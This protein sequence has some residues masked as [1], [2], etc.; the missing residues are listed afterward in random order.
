MTDLDAYERKILRELQSDASL[1]TAELAERIG[2]SPS[3]CWRRVDRL[4]REGVIRKRVALIDRRKVGLNAHVFAQVK[5]N[6]HGRANLDEFSAAIRG[7]PEVL[8]AY[9]LMGTMDFML[10]IVAE[11]IDAYERFFFDKLSKLPGVQ[12]INSIVALSEIKSTTELP[13]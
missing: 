2:L 7:F 6:A 4:E 11:D 3:P 9:V 13:I 5:L 8:D 12:E 1:T 10:R